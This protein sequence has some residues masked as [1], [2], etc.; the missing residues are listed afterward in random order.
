MD[1]DKNIMP[2]TREFTEEEVERYGTEFWPKLP[3]YRAEDRSI[4]SC[5]LIPLFKMMKWPRTDSQ[6]RQYTLF[7]EKTWGGRIKFENWR[8]AM[9]TAHDRIG[10]LRWTAETLD[11]NGDGYISREEYEFGMDLLTG[12]EP[13]LAK[14]PYEQMVR[15]A[16]VDGDG[17]ISI[18]EMIKW[19][20]TIDNRIR[21]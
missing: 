20:D 16:D 2:S 21:P 9:L 3:S 7:N 10:Y 6:I 19:L 12:H 15:E 13:E 5:D 18:E 4:E 8:G 14:V 17:R 1:G 11:S